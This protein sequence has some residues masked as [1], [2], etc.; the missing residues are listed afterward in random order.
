MEGWLV[1]AVAGLWV[2]GLGVVVTALLGGRQ[3][4]PW[5]DFA[6]WEQ[7]FSLWEHE[8]HAPPTTHR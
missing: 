8:F 4:A 1:W 3:H 2:A 7:D 6:L 5:N